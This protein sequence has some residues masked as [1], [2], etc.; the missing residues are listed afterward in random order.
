MPV[1]KRID[2]YKNFKFRVE[3]D[4]ITQSGF[5]EVIIPE[6]SADVIEY[7]EGNEP[8]RVRKLLGRIRY[9]NIILKSGLTNSLE[10]YNWWKSVE[11]GKIRDA[12]RGMSV[13]VM[14]DEGSDACRWN[15]I[16]AWPVKYKPSALVAKGND[17]VIE[18]LEIT[19][20]GMIRVQ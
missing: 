5:N 13:I 2:P 3:I 19:H 14:D 10:I 18:E 11:E 8:T 7:R 1:G 15:F 20:E 17:V 9:G 16:A 4:G 12:R 6:A